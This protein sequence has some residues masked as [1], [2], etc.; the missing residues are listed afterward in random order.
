MAQEASTKKRRVPPAGAILRYGV[1]L[2]AA[3]R[4]DEWPEWRRTNFPFGSVA[5]V[6]SHQKLPLAQRA[7]IRALKP[8]NVSNAE[9]PPRFVLANEQR[10]LHFVT[11]HAEWR[12][13]SERMPGSGR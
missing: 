11:G 5:L 13:R 8:S 1:V 10:R 4:R 6:R 7:C 3:L 2:I 9:R 12:V